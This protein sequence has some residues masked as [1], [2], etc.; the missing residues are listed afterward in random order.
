[1]S[2]APQPATSRGT[3]RERLERILYLLPAAS[4]EEG[5]SLDELTRTLDVTRDVLLADV[6]EVTARAYN[7]P[8]G[9]G[10]DLQVYLGADRLRVW[11]TGEF[12]RPPKLTPREGLA[13]GIGLRALAGE[14]G[15]EKRAGLLDLARRLEANLASIPV[16]DFTPRFAI[17]E[18]AETEAPG[19]DPT[20]TDP[21]D[22]NAPES[23]PSG[24]STAALRGLLIEAAR[25]ARA[26]CFPCLKADAEEPEPRRLEPYALVGATGRW[27][28]IGRDPD[29][30]DI[31]AFRLDRMLQVTVLDETYEPAE[32]F[33]LDAYLSG[34]RVYRAQDPATARVR[35]AP[36][37]ARWILER[38]EGEEEPGGSAIVDHEVADPDW[39]VRH[40]LQYA[41][42]AE[43]LGPDDLR[44][45]VGA[46]ATNVERVHSA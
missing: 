45:R 11:T 38:G 4:G 28:A 43:L 18:M 14:V 26:C 16:E 41:G 36:R 37:I 31:R 40:V 42:E 2:D 30:E 12:R 22:A 44:I 1:M 39:A 6:E 33:D 32:D 25:D 20:A 46:A 24:P 21:P 8:A 13:L 27:Y 23:E 10:D 15:V 29:R 17:E 9:G 3:A 7:H 35:Y 34:T 19:S 5:A